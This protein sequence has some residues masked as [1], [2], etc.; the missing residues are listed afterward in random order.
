MFKK[1]RAYPNGSIEYDYGDTIIVEDRNGFLYPKI[2][3][4]NKDLNERNNN[5]FT[6][7]FEHRSNKLSNN[8]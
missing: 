8:I 3:L 6:N 1:L 4:F 7:S 2:T 5:L